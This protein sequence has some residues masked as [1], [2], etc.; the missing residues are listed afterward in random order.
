MLTD[1]DGLR[2]VFVLKVLLIRLKNKEM[3][4]L[5]KTSQNSK[6]CL[7]SS[8]LSNETNF[9]ELDVATSWNPNRIL[10]TYINMNSL[11]NKFEILKGII[12]LQTHIDGFTS[13]YK[14]DKN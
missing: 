3:Q 5:I 9:N 1:N 8:D 11:R 6:K 10:I 4:I 14:F 2:V 7:S 13:P 12:K